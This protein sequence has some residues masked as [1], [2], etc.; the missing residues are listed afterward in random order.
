ML[1]YDILFGSVPMRLT[2]Q[3]KQYWQGEGNWRC[4]LLAVDYFLTRYGPYLTK[5]TRREK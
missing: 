1:R 3:S 2:R 5:D 4:W